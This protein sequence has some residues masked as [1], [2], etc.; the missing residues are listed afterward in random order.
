[1]NF[2]IITSLVITILVTIFVVIFLYQNNTPNPIFIKNSANEKIDFVYG[3]WPALKNPDFFNEVKADFINQKASFIEANLSSMEIRLYKDGEIIKEANIISKGKEGS[4]WETPVGLYKINTKEKNHFSS[5]GRVYMPWSMQFQGNFFI[6]GPTSYPDGSPTPSSYSG[7]CIRVALDDVEEIFNLA[8][9]GT[10][11][12]IFE[13][14]FDTENKT[15]NYTNKAPLPDET[16]YLVADLENNFVFTKNRASE[17]H[18]IA[19]ITKLMSALIA[20]EYINVEKEVTIDSSMI[21][22]TSAPRL[23]TGEKISVLDLLSV[24]LQESSNEA[25]EAIASPLGKNY[26]INLMNTKSKAIGMNNSNFADT[27]GALSGNISTAEDLFSLAKYLY[28]N[29]SFVLHMSMG[30]ENR[31]AYGDSKYKNLKNF[32]SIDGLNNMIGGKTGLSL[33]AQNTILAIFEIEINNQKRPV[34][35]IVLGSSDAK[36]DVVKLLSFIEDNFSLKQ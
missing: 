36:A 29:R 35:I 19:S 2:K 22:A 26:F 31:I 3:S 33:S 5:F 28:H 32:N 11:V 10:P 17:K 12:L 20:V 8:D 24:M 34:A 15:I 4:W 6:H 27:S 25:A 14:S 7:G 30:E 9:V 16:I 1:M 13:E 23:K 18:S 21:V